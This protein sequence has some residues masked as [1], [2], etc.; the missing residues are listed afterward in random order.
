MLGASFAAGFLGCLLLLAAE[1]HF[2]D[3]KAFRHTVPGSLIADASVWIGDLVPE[4]GDAQFIRYG[5]VAAAIRSACATLL[6]ILSYILVLRFV[7]GPGT[8][9]ERTSESKGTPS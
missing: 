6:G 1:D 4:E 8:W 2:A 9:N 7:R 3:M 5:E